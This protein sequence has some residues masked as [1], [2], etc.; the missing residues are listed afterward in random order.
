M[1]SDPTDVSGSEERRRQARRFSGTR[2]PLTGRG[3]GVEANSHAVQEASL[4]HPPSLPEVPQEQE[5]N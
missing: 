3:G 1:L 5:P 4:S 2:S